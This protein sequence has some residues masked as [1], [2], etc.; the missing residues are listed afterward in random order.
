MDDGLATQTN[1]QQS[2]SAWPANARSCCFPKTSPISGINI[3]LITLQTA[4][5][6]RPSLCLKHRQASQTFASRCIEQGQ[7]RARSLFAWLSAVSQTFS[8]SFK[9]TRECTSPGSDMASP[10][11]R[12]LMSPGRASCR[13]HTGDL[14]ASTVFDTAIYSFIQV[15]SHAMQ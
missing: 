10:H 5:D 4:A 3:R 15:L 8:A 6:F 11:D 13:C 14:E 1:H 2:V 7:S 9:C 12:A